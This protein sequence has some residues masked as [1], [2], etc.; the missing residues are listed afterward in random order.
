MSQNPY[1]ALEYLTN[2]QEE[3]HLEIQLKSGKK[4]QHT[5]PDIEGH[6]TN[7]NSL[8]KN[9]NFTEKTLHIPTEIS[10][11]A[12]RRGCREILLGYEPITTGK[13]RLRAEFS[14]FIARNEQKTGQKRAIILEKLQAYKIPD[15]MQAMFNRERADD[16]MNKL[17]IVEDASDS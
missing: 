12:F 5:P 17:K 1:A 15:N 14:E 13:H 6:S 2:P 9:A 8:L 7:Q 4:P 11:N 3:D 16:I 10:R